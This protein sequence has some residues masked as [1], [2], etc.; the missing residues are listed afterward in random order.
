[1]TPIEIV[2]DLRKSFQRTWEGMGP[3]REFKEIM[4][5]RFQ[6]AMIELESMAAAQQ[7]F[8]HY[9]PPSRHELSIRNLVAGN[10]DAEL[11]ELD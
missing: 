2:E 6:L 5:F 8:D 3:T 4:D 10:F 1:M 11:A 7:M 9:Y